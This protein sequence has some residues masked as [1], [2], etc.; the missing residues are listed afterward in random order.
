MLQTE[1]TKKTE[2]DTVGTLNG[3][4]TSEKVNKSH[5]KE[6]ERTEHSSETSKLVS[7]EKQEAFNLWVDKYKP[8]NIKQ[9][10]GQQGEKSCANKLLKWLKNW[11]RNH[12]EN[13]KINRP[14]KVLILILIL[15]PLCPT[16][17]K[18]PTTC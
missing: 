2:K 5:K 3:H 13:K 7:A 17:Y 1:E 18:I 8:T 10:I 16:Q 15:M 11:Y 14:S 4:I 9:I 6:T 12:S